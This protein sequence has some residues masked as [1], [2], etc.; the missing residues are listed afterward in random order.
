ME[1]IQHNWLSVVGILWGIDQILKIIAPLT[2]S[3]IDDN[4]ADIFGKVL[5]SFF[6]KP[7]A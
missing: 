1:W 6:K 2:K 7:S 3:T 5:A 4:I